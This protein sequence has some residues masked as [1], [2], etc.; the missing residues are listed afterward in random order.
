MRAQDKARAHL[1]SAMKYLGF[2]M[3]PDEEK[4][5]NLYVKNHPSEVVDDEAKEIWMKMKK[6]KRKHEEDAFERL[7]NKSD[8][9][10]VV[11]RARQVG[12]RMQ[13]GRN[14]YDQ[15]AQQMK[16]REQKQRRKMPD[17]LR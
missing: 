8:D 11:Q 6:A 3:T 16:R 14:K 13:E 12:N 17:L 15:I 2:G 10:D 7:T 4:E 1:Q 5:F 9:S